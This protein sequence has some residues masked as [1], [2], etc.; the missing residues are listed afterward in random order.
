M[1]LS[2]AAGV[3][4]G[5]KWP[6]CAGVQSDCVATMAKSA[7]RDHRRHT[8]SCWP[9]SISVRRRR[10]RQVRDD[11]AING[12]CV[13]AYLLACLCANLCSRLRSSRVCVELCAMCLCV[14]TGARRA[15]LAMALANYLIAGSPRRRLS[16]D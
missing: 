2:A 15:A 12:L 13:C 7:T 14:W 10:R 16:L 8:Q 6:A 9:K 11:D 3:C 5:E 1:L 4:L